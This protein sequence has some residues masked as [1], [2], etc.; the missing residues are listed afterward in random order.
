VLFY[1][2]LL[3]Q[4]LKQH[5]ILLKEVHHDKGFKVG[6]WVIVASRDPL[7]HISWVKFVITMSIIAVIA[8]VYSIIQGYV[9]FSQVMVSTLFDGI[10]AV[11]F[12]A[13][14]PWR[15]KPSE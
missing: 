9:E 1:S 10:S 14:Y 13:L 2:Q 5:P 11:V 15:A 8:G 7:R 6:V 4:L 3:G 12:L